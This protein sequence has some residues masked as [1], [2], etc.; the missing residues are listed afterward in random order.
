MEHDDD[1]GDG[2]VARIFLQKASEIEVKVREAPRRTRSKVL[3]LPDVRQGAI[4]RHFVA[5]QQIEAIYLKQLLHLQDVPRR[6]DHRPSIVALTFDRRE[7]ID[8]Y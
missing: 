2:Q 5:R 4:Q 1:G 3:F 6:N 7:L 8:I